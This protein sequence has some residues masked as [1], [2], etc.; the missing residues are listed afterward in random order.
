MQGRQGAVLKSRKSTSGLEL[1]RSDVQSCRTFGPLK[2]ISYHTE[3]ENYEIE[4]ETIL[5]A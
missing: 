4:P 2:S 5:T 3:S 1:G